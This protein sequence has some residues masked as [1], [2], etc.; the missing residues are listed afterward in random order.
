MK[1]G[2][3]GREVE[4]GVLECPY[5]HYRFEV[6]A[7]VLTPHER[8]TFDGVTIEEDGSTVD[9]KNVSGG[10]G[11]GYE[12]GSYGRGQ[13]YEQ[14]QQRQQ[15]PGIKVHT[16][17]CGSGLLMTLLILGGILALVFFLL[18][19]FIVFAAIGAVV[20]FILRLFA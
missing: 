4:K 3:C 9:N 1:C 15:T 19:T 14:G 6:D 2:F 17:G 13:S 11:R 20:V 5:C 18:P 10:Q 8:D 12:Q 7:Q 16:F